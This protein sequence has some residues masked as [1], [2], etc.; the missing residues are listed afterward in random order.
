MPSYEATPEEI[1]QYGASLNIWDQI[2]LLS[3]WSPLIAYLQRWV[4]TNDPY[5]RAVIGGEMCEWVASRTDSK[6]DDELVK[7]IVAVL[8]TDECEKLIRFCLTL[9]GAK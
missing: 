3:A 6:V 4:A 2:R 9:V 7:H 5:Q 1:Q 8:G